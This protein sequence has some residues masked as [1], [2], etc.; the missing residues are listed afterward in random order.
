ME[1]D[2]S[3]IDDSI[4]NLN[5]IIFNNNQVNYSG[6]GGHIFNSYYLNNIVTKQDKSQN[7][8]NAMCS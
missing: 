6:I 3:S 2:Y 1:F 5:D 7:I 4:I 8:Y